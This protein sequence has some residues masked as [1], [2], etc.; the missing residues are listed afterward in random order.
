MQ[1]RNASSIFLALLLFAG[2]GHSSADT[3]D[4]SC[5]VYPRGSDRASWYGPCTFSQRQGAVGIQLDNG[6]RYDLSPVGDGPGQYRDQKGRPAHRESGMGNAG[7]IYRLADDSVM[8][9]WDA[10]KFSKGGSGHAGKGHDNHEGPRPLSKD[11]TGLVGN[12]RQDAEQ[13][14]ERLGFAKVEGEKNH[15]STN[16]LWWNRSSSDCL[17]VDSQDGRVRA[18]E[19]AERSRCD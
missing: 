5:E 15:G 18:I 2:A 16:A 7:Q 11:I 12:K 13:K 14:L 8:V 17:S 10:G 3:V 9:Y 19:R 4:A 6:K 1:P